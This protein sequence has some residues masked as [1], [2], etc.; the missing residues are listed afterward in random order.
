MKCTSEFNLTVQNNHF[1]R[2]FEFWDCVYYWRG[3]EIRTKHH[4]SHRQLHIRAW[5]NWSKLIFLEDLLISGI[6][7]NLHIFF[8]NA[9]FRLENAHFW[10]IQLSEKFYIFQKW[11][12]FEKST[13]EKWKLLKSR[14]FKSK[15]LLFTKNGINVRQ[16]HFSI[17]W[18]VEV[19]REKRFRQEKL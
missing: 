13:I 15:N 4:L 5:L 6:T 11:Y 14:F 18:G 1:G 16:Y 10:K 17:S 3:P 19:S 9:Q 2:T 8:I 7:L 12:I